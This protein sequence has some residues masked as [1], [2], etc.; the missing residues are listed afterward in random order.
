[1]QMAVRIFLVLITLCVFAA[2]GVFVLSFFAR[3]FI[4]H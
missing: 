3:L 1:M 2:A 4:A